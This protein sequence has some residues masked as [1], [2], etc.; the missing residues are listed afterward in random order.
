LAIGHIPGETS[1]GVRL[2][3][4]GPDETVTEE[5]DPMRANMVQ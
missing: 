5:A 4:D 1:F 3:E 2:L